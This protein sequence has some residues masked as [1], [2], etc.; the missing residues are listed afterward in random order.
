MVFNAVKESGVFTS[1]SSDPLF[2]YFVVAFL[3]LFVLLLGLVTS[4]V[5]QIRK[6]KENIVHAQAM[7]NLE[8]ELAT[9]QKNVADIERRN[10]YLERENL[11]LNPYAVMP[12]AFAEIQVHGTRKYNIESGENQ[13]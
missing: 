1:Y 12:D 5:M 7:M 8:A 4:I 6:S 9:A 2:Y 11:R 3:L 13:C 10:V